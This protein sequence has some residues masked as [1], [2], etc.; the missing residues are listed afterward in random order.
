MSSGPAADHPFIHPFINPS[1]Y[2]SPVI[3]HISGDTF[4][5]V[6]FVHLPSWYNHSTNVN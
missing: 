4:L 3:I 5:R 1:I 6:A 2:P